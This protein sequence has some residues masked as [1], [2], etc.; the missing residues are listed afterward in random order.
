MLALFATAAAATS[1]ADE[2]PHWRNFHLSSGAVVQLEAEKESFLQIQDLATDIWQTRPL[3]GSGSMLAMDV[4]VRD[5]WLEELRGLPGVNASTFRVVHPDLLG[6]IEG[7]AR[8]RS[9]RWSKPPAGSSHARG[10]ENDTF[11]DE[12]RPQVGTSSRA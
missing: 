8:L 7:Q 2:P 6:R 11:F 4:Q 10:P 5:D 9:G 1:L 12:F 3:P